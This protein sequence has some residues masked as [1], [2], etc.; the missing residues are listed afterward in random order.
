MQ[1]V[2]IHLSS[3]EDV[4]DFVETIT[5]LDGNFDLLS[6]HYIL[7]ARSLMGI[8]T[9][10]LTKPLTLKVYD[11]SPENMKAIEKYIVKQNSAQ[12]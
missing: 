10:D 4:Q 6:G 12:A 7:D 11:D 2:L 3:S 5:G 8:F 9:L 1:T